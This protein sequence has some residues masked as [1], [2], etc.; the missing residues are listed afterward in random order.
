MMYRGCL[1]VYTH[2][3]PM[4]PW[5]YICLGCLHFYI[6]DEVDRKAGHLMLNRNVLVF[7]VPEDSKLFICQHEQLYGYLASQ[8]GIYG[9][10]QALDS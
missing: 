9:F 4:Y 3:H 10:S 6:S 5:I 1:G 7:K 8:A 2:P